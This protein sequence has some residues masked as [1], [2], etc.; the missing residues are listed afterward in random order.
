[1]RIH[2]PS[3]STE[4]Q[5]S[6]QHRQNLLANLTIP[7]TQPTTTKNQNS[8][9]AISTRDVAETH[10]TETPPKQNQTTKTCEQSATK[11]LQKDYI[12]D[13]K[14]SNSF[15]STYM[16]YSG[17]RGN[18]VPNSWLLSL[19]I[20][21]ITLPQWLDCL[22]HKKQKGNCEQDPAQSM[23]NNVKVER[24]VDVERAVEELRLYSFEREVLSSALT[25]I[26][27][28]EVKGILKVSERDRLAE[29]YKQ[30]LRVLE[31]KIEERRKIADLLNLEKEKRELQTYYSEK[32]NEIEKKIEDLR[33]LIGS[34]PQIGIHTPPMN[35][36]LAESLTRP[37]DRAEILNANQS[38]SIDQKSDKT[39]TKTEERIEALREEVL[40]A[41]ER[42][43][44]IESE[45]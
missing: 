26:Y 23:Q 30:S 1:M 21:C 22:L 3:Q 24:D 38:S 11:T 17:S 45:T 6:T 27:E 32:M 13:E 40:R 7:F 31:Q 8:K 29:P 35:S 34:L 9:P 18:P 20:V 2:I 36:D 43:E 15:I 39:R 33:S 5:R 44:Q 25:S 42:L 10:Q 19:L 12:R 41:I 28:A 16:R 37:D 14:S 4:P